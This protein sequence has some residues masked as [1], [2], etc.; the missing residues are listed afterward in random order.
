[1]IAK[2]RISPIRIIVVVTFLIMVIVNGLANTLPINNQTTGGISD[3]YENLF[4]PA[5][6]TFAVWG[7]IYALLL[8]YSIYQLDIFKNGINRTNPM[9]LDNIGVIFSISSIANTLWI[10]A[11]HYEVIWL[12]LI[13]IVVV[14]VCLIL[15]NREIMKRSLCFRDKLFIRLPFSI[16]FGWITV[17]TIANATVFL[18]SINWNG[19]GISDTLWTIVVLFVG[20][21][22]ATINIVKNKDMAYGLTIIWAYVGILIKHTS[23]SGFD[24]TYP[25]IISAVS[26]LIAFL[27]IVEIYTLITQNKKIYL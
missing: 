25:S 23:K 20:F 9:L 12:S 16:Y 11:W 21:L 18:V 1:M 24:G 2:K 19:F 5:G 7:L 27:F 13:L 22:I 6:Y 14:L 8:I 3:A 26:V 10:F 4:A 15:I 17:A